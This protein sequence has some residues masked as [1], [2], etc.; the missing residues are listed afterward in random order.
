MAM[1]PTPSMAWIRIRKL[2]EKIQYLLP[3]Q[4]P[5]SEEQ[6][7]SVAGATPT[8]KKPWN[9][10]VRRAMHVIAAVSRLHKSSVMSRGGQC[11]AI[12]NTRSVEDRE[13]LREEPR[14][15]KSDKRSRGQSDEPDGLK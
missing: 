6:L 15:Q 13:C 12:P 14:G 7:P 1:T 5:A 8:A 4:Q 11:S 3:T 10:S 9:N 2:S